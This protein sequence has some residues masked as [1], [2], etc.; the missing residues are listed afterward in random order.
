MRTILS[1]FA[2]S[3]LYS[4]FCGG[5]KL[6]I[7]TAFMDSL[8]VY[9]WIISKLG[10]D[11]R[12]T[13]FTWFIH[14]LCKTS[15]GQWKRIWCCTHVTVLVLFHFQSF[16]PLDQMSVFYAHPMFASTLLTTIH[17]FTVIKPLVLAVSKFNKYVIWYW[18]LTYQ[19]ELYHKI[20]LHLESI[21][22]MLQRQ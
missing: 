10:S 19:L 7:Y 4:C 8:W 13:Y 21:W 17:S 20:C 5:K 2:T 3:F 11:P 12:F 18:R 16:P 9:E 14:S 6:M 1:L 22:L 15:V